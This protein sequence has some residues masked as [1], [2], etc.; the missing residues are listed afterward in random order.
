RR[1]QLWLIGAGHNQT[2]IFLNQLPGLENLQTP[3]QG[4]LQISGPSISVASLKLRYSERGD[5]VVVTTPPV[6]AESAAQ[7]TKSLFPYFADGGGFPTQFVLFSKIP[8]Q[9]YT[10]ILRF[11]DS[12]AI[13][14]PLPVH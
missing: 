5:L 9:D 14:L 2:D 1:P 13:R 4:L 7:F 6:A 12:A 3:F 11:V 8:G 10:G